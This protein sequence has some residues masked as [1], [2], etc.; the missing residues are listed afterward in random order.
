MLSG[1]SQLTL[2]AP[3]CLGVQVCD[4]SPWGK[5]PTFSGAARPAPETRRHG[6]LPAGRDFTNHN[7]SWPGAT[8]QPSYFLPL[9]IESASS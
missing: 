4:A 3:S 1:Q 5:G 7:L 9:V 6:R 8:H 2:S